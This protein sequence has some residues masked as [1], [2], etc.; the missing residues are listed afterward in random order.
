MK[1][2]ELKK[3]LKHILKLKIENIKETINQHIISS[4]EAM[5]VFDKTN[6]IHLEKLN[7]TYDT[8]KEGLDRNISR[9]KYEMGHEAVKQKI[10]QV[11]KTMSE[12]K[13][14]SK[15]MIII[16]VFIA[17]V[18]ASIITTVIVHILK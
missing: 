17:S 7:H 13:G 14:E 12:K 10:E 8:V 4:K 18:A 16:L 9:E 11:E 1:K 5:N 6:Q 2:K 3:Y 15:V